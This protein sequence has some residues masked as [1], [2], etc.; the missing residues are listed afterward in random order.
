MA[1]RNGTADGARVEPEII[2]KA[3]GRKKKKRMKKHRFS[4]RRDRIARTSADAVEGRRLGQWE[5]EERALRGNERGGEDG[6]MP[7]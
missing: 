7:G 4:A 2:S 6:H 3:A 5:D 1:E